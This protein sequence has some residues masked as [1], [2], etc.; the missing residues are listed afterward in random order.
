MI[1]KLYSMELENQGD[2]LDEE[3]RVEVKAILEKNKAFI[4]SENEHGRSGEDLA[5]AIAELGEETGF[6]RGFKCAF[7]LFME[8]NRE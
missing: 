7:R 2:R 8:C 4:S 6:V 1:R 3:M 5:F